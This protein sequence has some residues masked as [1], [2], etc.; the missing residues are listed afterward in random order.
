[1]EGILEHESLNEISNV[2]AL[3]SALPAIT[4]LKD[5]G[6]LKKPLIR[7]LAGGTMELAVLP[8]DDTSGA[9]LLGVWDFG[10]FSPLLR[11]F[12]VFSN[13]V[14]IPN[15]YYVQAG[16]NSRF[17]LRT[18]GMTLFIGPYRNLLYI[19]DNSAV[20][21]SR[22]K[23]QIAPTEDRGFNNV[24]PSAYDAAL[25]ISTDFI[26]SL[27]S[28]QDQSIAELIKNISFESTVEAGISVHQ[29]KLEFRLMAPLSSHRAPLSRLLDKKSQAP[30]ISDRIPS[31]A[32]YATVLS[33]G[34]LEELYQAAMVFSGPMLE[35]A[36]RMADSSS[37]VVLGL[38]L[39]D[40]LFSWSGNEFAAFGMEGRPHPVYAIQIDDERKRQAVFDQAFKSVVL[41][42]NVRL[43]LDGVRIP[44]IEIPEFLQNLL[45]RWNLFLPSPYYTIYKDY[46]LVSES[47][48]TL[49]AAL[50][51]MQKN[52][53]LPKTA[54]WRNIAGGRTAASAVSLYYS[55]DLSMPFFLR[56]NTT[57]SGFIGLYRQGLVRLSFDRGI[58]DISLALVPG[59]GSGI[60]LVNSVAFDTQERL[61]NRIYGAGKGDNSRIFISAVSSVFAYNPS[62]NKIVNYS[63]RGQQWIV[64]AE[65]TGDKNAV[66]AWVVSQNGR[67]TLMNS[68]LEAQGGFPILTG[69]RL[70]SPP[71]S[72]NGRLYLCDEDGK[73]HAIDAKGEQST[74][75][76]TFISKLLSPPSFLSVTSRGNVRHFA[77]VY[78]KSFFEKAIWLLDADGK[79]A[80]G[81]PA[82]IVVEE[83]EEA[84]DEG[85]YSW[86]K[87]LFGSSTKESQ[88]ASPGIGFGSPFVFYYNNNVNVAFISQDGELFVYDEA[89][90]A[91]QPFPLKLNGIFYLQPVFDGQYLW[92]VSSEGTLYRI[93]LDGE[94]LFQDIPNFSVKEEGYITTFDCDN[95]KVPEVFITGEG[96]ALYAYTRNFRSL[97]GFPLPMWGRPHFVEA[98]GNKK[99][100]IY[101]MGMDRK[102]HFWQFR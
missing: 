62:E 48:D 10:F 74:W 53:V 57:L 39:N 37:R 101:G 66:N 20:F 63:D 14:T 79:A 75:E 68:E 52:D 65:G 64:P 56:K 54:V 40:L 5:T 28:E 81:W 77:A 3:A 67:V 7:M 44:R 15:L 72:Y 100:G 61:S 84:E 17:E 88:P 82:S 19:T 16:R 11:I 31:T 42:E 36:F 51:A 55:L 1:M 85:Q 50:R 30:G 23:T 38:S 102:L 46:L 22:T 18:E 80:A 6:L 49:L 69:Y 4:M 86:F 98:Q 95:D 94:V 71:V 59:S 25:L 83:E 58:I 33:A 8:A 99:A 93:S 26:S 47:A 89:A 27:L 21:E 96:N 76:T 12:P 29:K 73:V 35:D 34:T 87:D 24:K 90:A 9:K 45:K 43:N 13:F 91:V 60:T 92:L 41:N 78:P 70:S 2:P 97:E 32:Q